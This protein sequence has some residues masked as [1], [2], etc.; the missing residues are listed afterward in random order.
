MGRDLLSD[1]LRRIALAS[2]TI[3][4]SAVLFHAK[5]EGA[6][7][8]YL[9]CA[10]FIE[11]PEDSFILFMPMETLVATFSHIGAFEE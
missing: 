11:F 2:Q 9:S 10:E 1:A 8:F 7:A 5:D 6:K 4:I 3:G